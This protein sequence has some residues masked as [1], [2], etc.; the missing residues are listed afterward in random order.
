MGIYRTLLEEEVPHITPNDDTNVDLKEIEDIVDDHDA[1]EAEQQDAQDAAFGPDGGVDDIL[2]ESAMAIFEFECTQNAILK[3]IG[4]HELTEA[5]AGREFVFEAADI[6]GFF[7]KAKEA[8]IKFFKKVWAVLQKW[9]GNLTITF[10]TNKKILEKHEKD[11]A[12]GYAKVTGDKNAKKMKGYTF[13]GLNG[14]IASEALDFEGYKPADAA[15]KIRAAIDS[16]SAAE[17]LM[18]AEQLYSNLAEIRRM[19]AGSECT[20]GEFAATLK[21]NLF[22]GDAKEM[23]M[24]VEDV[25]SNLKD[26]KG[27]KEKAN[28]F[29]KSSKKQFQEQIKEFNNLEKAAAKLD[30]GA[31]RN[32]IMAACTRYNK[33]V[34]TTLSL[35]QTRRSGVLTAIR[36]RAAQSRSYALRYIRAANGQAYE[37]KK[38]KINGESAYGF[39]GSLNL[40]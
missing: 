31:E 29:M 4:M 3:T 10:A 37:E 33:L 20:A 11:L 36:A 24:S 2:D 14:K 13:D 15:E 38:A 22:G 16:K 35:Y 23:W 28:A 19:L 40:V 17:G 8:V 30:D 12:A 7:T 1:N 26:T 27:D 5:V 18:D 21:K 9:A 25:K 32:A 34:S 39:L 6:K